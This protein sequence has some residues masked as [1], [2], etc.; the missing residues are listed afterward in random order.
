MKMIKKKF[1]K[2]KTSSLAIL[3]V[4]IST[5]LVSGGQ[6]FIK[7]GLNKI[8]SF[9][10]FSIIN[11]S[12]I[13]GL[14]L[15]FFAFILVLNSLKLG[16]LSV[17]YPIIALDYIWVTILSFLFLNETLNLWKIFGVITIFFGVVSIGIGGRK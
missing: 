17:L 1:K 5:F 9:S 16:E 2:T 3:L 8:S 7:L 6:F 4:F 13:L 10:L 12:L 15:Y 11:I 14:L